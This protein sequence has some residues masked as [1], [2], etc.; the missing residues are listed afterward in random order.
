VVLNARVTSPAPATQP[1]NIATAWRR[2]RLSGLEPG[3]RPR[4]GDAS[5]VNPTGKLLTAAQP[6]MSRLAAILEGT[7]C[8]VMLT[9]RDV[10]FVD[11]R[12]GTSEIDDAVTLNGAV[13][14]RAFSEETSGTNAVATVHEL[15]APLAV[16]GDQHFIESMKKF[17]CY[18][19]PILHPITRRIEGVL[20]LT[21]F[22]ADD[23][24]LFQPILEQAA[25]DIQ[26]RLLEQSPRV[27]QVLF[28]DFQRASARRRDAPV[29]A[30]ANDVVLANSTAIAQLDGVDFAALAT[31]GASADSGDMRTHTLNSGRPVTLRW[32]RS[33]PNGGIV[34]E[35]SPSSDPA[36]RAIDNRAHPRPKNQS[37]HRQV[38]ETRRHRRPMSVVGEPGTGRTTLLRELMAGTDALT[39]D[40]VNLLYQ[41]EG[42][43]LQD[44]GDALHRA[45]R[46]VIVENVHLLSPMLATE[47]LAVTQRTS[48]WFALSSGPLNRLSPEVFQ[49]VD[50]CHTRLELLPLRLRKHD[51]PG[52]ILNMLEAMGSRVHFT[53][54]AI[55]TLLAHNWPGNIS[56]L[57]AEVRAAA[58]LRSVGDI[59]DKD[60]GRLHAR[61]GTPQLSALDAVLRATI[62]DE[63]LR[64]QGNKL[65]AARAL[66]ISRTTLYKRM[67][68]FGI[69]G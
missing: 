6:V 68:D 10:R 1:E 47:M 36:E 48:A 61:A 19:Y 25:R 30:M 69:S 60:L 24:P 67:R 55:S 4:L 37:I 22:V 56:E 2:A 5:V 27:E 21:F 17:S 12:Y 41:S 33:V 28:A 39:F 53:P 62:E 26:G 49:L 18:G 11:L 52:L 32:T 20:C 35:L 9:D 45:E 7:H 8:C 14:G 58:R 40:A 54:G 50:S 3:H 59:T 43:W 46:A 65:A 38:T 66:N 42:Q 23:N 63:L 51:I 31:L 44:V 64:N 15:R 16:Y 13:L 34:V 29:V 57:E